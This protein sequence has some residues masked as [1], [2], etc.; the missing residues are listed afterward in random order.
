MQKQAQADVVHPLALGKRYRLADEAPEA[1][2]QGVVPPLDV[3]AEPGVFPARRMLLICHH[4]LLR[5]PEVAV[6]VG[7]AVGLGNLPLQ[8]LTGGPAAVAN[9]VGHNLPRRPTE[10]NPDPMF[11]Y[12]FQDN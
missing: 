1:L 5:F 6:A 2:A 8:L 7:T 9:H 12:L 3:R 10:R 11:M 4:G